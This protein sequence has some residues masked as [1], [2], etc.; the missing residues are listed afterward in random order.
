MAGACSY[1]PLL[2]SRHMSEV[3]EGESG[4]GEATCAP[5]LP[6]QKKALCF[7]GALYLRGRRW[8][9]FWTFRPTEAFGRMWK[10]EL[11]RQ[12]PGSIESRICSAQ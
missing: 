4:M 8:Q 7:D 12:S 11:V 2:A 6:L 10:G 1:G 9:G 3:D 5:G